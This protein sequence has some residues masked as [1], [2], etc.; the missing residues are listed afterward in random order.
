[1]ARSLGADLMPL[2][3]EVGDAAFE[4]VTNRHVDLPRQR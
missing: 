3:S 2:L 4:H 1:M